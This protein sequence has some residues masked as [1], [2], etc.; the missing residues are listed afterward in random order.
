M[1]EK[2]DT[3]YW[4]ARQSSG[5]QN[6]RGESPGIPAMGTSVQ[7]HC[8]KDVPGG[9]MA[10]ERLLVLDTWVWSVLANLGNPRQIT[11]NKAALFHLW[12]Y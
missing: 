12:S 3:Q 5:G 8:S 9:F 2:F 4:D 6:K 7:R 10:P 11:P 1:R